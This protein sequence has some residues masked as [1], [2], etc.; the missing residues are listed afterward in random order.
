MLRAGPERPRPVSPLAWLTMHWGAHCTALGELTSARTHLEQAI[1]LYDPQQHPRSTVHTADPRVACLSYAAWILWYLGYPDQAL[2]RSQEALTL[3]EEL[4]HPFSLAYALTVLPC[5]ISSAGRGS[6]PKSGQRRR[7]R[8][9][10]SRGFR[11]GWRL[12]LSC[13]AGRWPSRDRWKKGIAQMRQG[14]AAYRATG[15]SYAAVF[16]CPAGRGVWESRTGRRRAE[17]A[18]R[19]AGYSGQNWGA[20]Y[21]AELYRLKGRADASKVKGKVEGAKSQP[22]HPAPSTQHRAE[23]EA[24]FLKAIEI[25]RKQ[26]AKSLELR[27]VMSLRRLWQQQGKQARSS[28]DVVRDLRL[29]HRR[30]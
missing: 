12:G 24:C 18:G 6:A 17:R 8:S 5:S 16:S 9:R 7:L 27:A 1:A 25:A 11:S 21:E 2:K 20:F 28:Q 15:Q 13:G 26:Q 19:G 3:A 22:S 23:A 29:V 30:V 14:L 4:S 10:L